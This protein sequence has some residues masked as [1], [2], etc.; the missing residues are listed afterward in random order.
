MNHL[1]SRFSPLLYTR[2]SL[3]ITPASLLLLSL[4]RLL[5]A[6]A[7]PPKSFAVEEYLVSTCGLTRAQ[8]LKAS[9]KLAHLRS[10]SKPDAVIA[11]LSALGLSR[12]GIAA[13]VASDPRFLCA[14][15]SKTLA[16][17][18]TELSHLGLSRA[19]MARLVPL[20]RTS[21]RRRGLGPNL[22]F[23]LPVMG[24]FENVLTAHGSQ[25]EIQPPRKRHREGGQAQP[26]PPPAVRRTCVRFPPFIPAPGS[27]GDD[28]T[29]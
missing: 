16:P 11:F 25:A 29:P 14:S 15:V 7:T 22:A 10:P 26:G 24:S 21:F 8:A 5:S 28:Q 27:R 12:P 4:H 20:A 13:L 18:V 17:R 1:R 9:K 6:T 3:P 2:C 19:Q 23:W